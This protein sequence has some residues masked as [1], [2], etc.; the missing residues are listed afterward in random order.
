AVPAAG[1]RHHL[2]LTTVLDRFSDSA[3][4]YQAAR[5]ALDARPLGRRVGRVCG[6]EVRP[7]P[8][9]RPLR[10]LAYAGARAPRIASTANRWRIGTALGDLCEAGRR[11]PV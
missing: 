3:G 11:R 10:S 1:L 8:R 6:G 7:R 4:S 9:C 5:C 2:E